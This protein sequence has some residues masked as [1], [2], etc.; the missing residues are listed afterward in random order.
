MTAEVDDV[1]LAVMLHGHLAPGL[2]LGVRMSR[3]AME[4][5][6]MKKGNRRYV[7]VSETSRCLADAMQA[8]TGCTLGH[9][10]A[11]IENYG[12]LAITLARIDTK[13]GIRIALRENAHEHSPLMRKWMLREGKL[14]RKEE[15]LLGKELLKLDEKYL[16]VKKIKINFESVFDASEIVKC[17]ECGELVPRGTAVIRDRTLCRSCAGASYY[18]PW[19]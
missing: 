17:E 10:N 9:G 1:E 19:I 14:T 6:R 18:T 5:L 13:E 2:A 12:K 11:F 8:T 15:E 3:L 7:A 16:E 4:R